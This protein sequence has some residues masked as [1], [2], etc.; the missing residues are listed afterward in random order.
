M[1]ELPPFTKAVRSAV[2]GRLL[3][4]TEGSK[5]PITVP[6]V[7]E[8]HLLPAIIGSSVYFH[9]ALGPSVGSWPFFPVGGVLF[10]YD[11]MTPLDIEDETAY[12]LTPA[13]NSIG[14]MDFGT[15]EIYGPQ[16]ID[17]PEDLIA[18]VLG[19]A[20]QLGLTPW[21]DHEAASAIEASTGWDCFDE[22][23]ALPIQEFPEA[24]E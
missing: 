16:E 12:H 3:H 17:G 5:G 13:D 11:G 6:V 23:M 8:A 14:F 21:N 19:A 1:S 7:L 9:A 22:F 2:S 20:D 4:T 15:S 24:S 10:T 18:C